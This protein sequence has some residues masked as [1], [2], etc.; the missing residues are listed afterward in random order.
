MSWWNVTAISRGYLGRDAME[1]AK[2]RRGE[3]L[4]LRAA[5]RTQLLVV[6]SH[7]C[8]PG[9]APEKVALVQ[10]GVISACAQLGKPSLITRVVDTMAKSP[11]PTRCN[12]CSGLISGF[13]VPPAAARCCNSNCGGAPVSK[14][15]ILRSSGVF[16]GSLKRDAQEG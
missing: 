13:R 14:R 12:N 7:P 8:S 16:L 1:R 15:H 9:Q 11:R 5:L 4:P 3:C 10:K 6:H 2:E